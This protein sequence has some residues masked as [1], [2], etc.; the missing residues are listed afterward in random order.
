M[1]YHYTRDLV[2][3]GFVVVRYIPAVDEQADILTKEYI[4][5]NFRLLRDAVMGITTTNLP[6]RVVQPV[7]TIQVNMVRTGLG[8]GSGAGGSGDNPENNYNEGE[9]ES[10]ENND[11]SDDDS[12]IVYGTDDDTTEEAPTRAGLNAQGD[13]WFAATCRRMRSFSFFDDAEC[14]EKW[15]DRIRDLETGVAQ[16]V[17]DSCVREGNIHE[18]PDQLSPQN[19][20]HTEDF[21]AGLNRQNT[22]MGK[23]STAILH[24]ANRLLLRAAWFR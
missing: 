17:I 8:E 1:Q 6:V 7:E 19:R 20:Y 18:W 14:S 16:S 22:Q 13:E 5:K 23:V 21:P 24:R 15:L 4:G 3:E 12:H 11:L 10:V 9:D 2:D